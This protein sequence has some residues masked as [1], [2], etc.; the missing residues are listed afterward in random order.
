LRFRNTLQLCDA[1]HHTLSHHSRFL[2]RGQSS[3]IGGC[4]V[5]YSPVGDVYLHIG[6]SGVY[7]LYPL[8]LR[9]FTT[10]TLFSLNVSYSIRN[11]LNTNRSLKIVYFTFMRM[12]NC[13]CKRN[14]LSA[15]HVRDPD[16]RSVLVENPG[17]CG[18]LISHRAGV[19]IRIHMFDFF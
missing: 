8:S 14:V 2:F 10:L 15:L 9:S 19:E 13:T 5:Y 6:W 11:I 1:D 3:R 7:T 17:T 18:V 4:C 12:W 16:S